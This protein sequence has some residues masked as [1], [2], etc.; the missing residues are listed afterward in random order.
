MADRDSGTSGCGGG[1]D[2][3]APGAV[4]ERLAAEAFI[5][6]GV[7]PASRPG[8]WRRPSPRSRRVSCCRC[9]VWGQMKGR[10][11]CLIPLV[12]PAQRTDPAGT[13]IG[14]CNLDVNTA[15]IGPP[16]FRRP[17]GG[18]GE[19]EPQ[20]LI[21]PVGGYRYGRGAPSVEQHGEA[22]A[23]KSR[24]A[25]LEYG[26]RRDLDEGVRLGMEQHRHRGIGFGPG[27][28]QLPR[29]LRGGWRGGLRII[30]E[31]TGMPDLPSPAQPECDGV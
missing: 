6:G 29:L 26:V 9:G 24:P 27:R 4:P 16:E 23:G 5:A 20:P 2:L 7:R 8:T 12:G 10:R 11:K 14:Q 13:A 28:C 30:G 17:P 22:R 21:P 19:P 18:T 31:E 15:D 3:I 25:Q 1:G